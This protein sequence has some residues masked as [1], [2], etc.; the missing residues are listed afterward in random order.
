MECMRE[1]GEL[2]PQAHALGWV[3][4]GGELYLPPVSLFDRRLSYF[5]PVPILGPFSCRFG[6]LPFL[7]SC[8][9]T[10]SEFGFPYI[11]V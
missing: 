10:S 5:Y 4:D 2:R 1:G 7:L 9:L 3:R 8:F 6:F 11:S